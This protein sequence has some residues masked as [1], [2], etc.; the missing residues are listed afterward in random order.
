MFI[1]IKSACFV[2][3]F[4]GGLALSRRGQRQPK[5][6]PGGRQYYSRGLWVQADL[7]SRSEGYYP[8]GAFTVPLRDKYTEQLQL[9]V[10]RRSPA[11]T[12]QHA[13]RRRNSKMERWTARM[14]ATKV[15]TMNT[16]KRKREGRVCANGRMSNPPASEP[17]GYRELSR[18]YIVTQY[19]AAEILR[20][21]TTE[22]KDCC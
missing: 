21:Q 13:S 3:L 20:V 8:P 4:T 1:W 17:L 22:Y 14:A 19:P 16:K 6:R 10:P 15:R 2:W 12:G 11:A 18:T 5:K 7:T 9:A